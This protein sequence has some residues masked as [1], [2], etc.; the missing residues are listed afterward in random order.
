M[1][2]VALLRWLGLANGQRPRGQSEQLTALTDVE[3]S[4]ILAAGCVPTEGSN[5]REGDKE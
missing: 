1:K 2:A 4:A 3:R 5:L